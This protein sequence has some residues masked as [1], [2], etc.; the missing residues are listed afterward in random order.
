[1]KPTQPIHKIVATPLSKGGIHLA[2]DCSKPIVQIDVRVMVKRGGD[3]TPRATV[4]HAD[5]VFRRDLPLTP[6]HAHKEIKRISIVVTFDDE[7]NQHCFCDIPESS[8]VH[9]HYDTEWELTPENEGGPLGRL[10]PGS[11]CPTS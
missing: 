11:D 2:V 9:D 5:T 7:S 10:C 4:R 8:P 3:D 6:S 1:M